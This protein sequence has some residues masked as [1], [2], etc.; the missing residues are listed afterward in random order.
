MLKHVLFILIFIPI[1]LFGQQTKISGVVKDIASG[2][3][4]AF[5][6]IQFVGSKIGVETDSLGQYILETYYATDSVRCFASGYKTMTFPI[7]KDKKQELN[8]NLSI[9]L[10]EIEE[11][12]VLPPDELP[13]VRL[14][15]KI[16]KNKPIND[17]EKL[18]SYEYEVYNK[19]QLD[20]NNLGDKFKNKGL[21]KKMDLILGYIDSIE[22]KKNYL[23]VVFTESLSDYYYVKNPTRKKEVQKASRVVG[24]DN[25]QL[26]QIVGE[27]YLD[28]NIY[29]NNIKVINRTFISPIASF[30]RNHYHFLIVD[31]AYIDK[32][33]C[34]KMTYRPKR[35][36]EMTFE[37]E[38]WVHDTTYAIK[39]IKGTISPNAN[40]NLVQDLVF[41]QNFEMVEHEVWM[42]TEEKIFADFNLL[43]KTS[44]YGV[45]GRKYSSR[46]HFK[47]NQTYPDKFYNS[48]NNVDALDSAK[49]RSQAY[50]ETHRHVPLSF[51]E[52]KITEMADN[53]RKQPFFKNMQSVTQMLV[54]GYFPY[55]YFEFGHIYKLFS[56]NPAEKFRMGFAIR[57]SNKFSKRLELGAKGYYGFGDNKFKY[58]AT[59]R[60]NVTPKKRGM[61]SAYYS[62]DIEQIGTSAKS[63]QVGTTFGTLIRTGPLDKL[64]FVEK[65]GINFEKDIH[66]D[67]IAFTGFEW[68][69]YVPVG[70]ADYVKK[71]L[72][73]G[74]IDSIRSVTATE[75]TLRIRWAKDE[76]FIGGHFD[77][78]SIIKS[79]YPEL[80]FQ[81]ILGIKGAL[82]SDYQYQKY[83]FELN[84]RQTLGPAGYMR[85]GFS[86]GFI[87]GTAA[88]PFLKVHEGSQ[89]YYL[90]KSNFNMMRFYEFVSDKYVDA[91]VENHWGG[92]FLNYIPWVKKLQWRFVTSARTAWGMLDQRHEKA[93]LLPDFIKRFNDTPYL[94]VSLGIENI[95]KFAR[96]DL[97]YR[98]THQ[99]P[100]RSPLGVRAKFEFAL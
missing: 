53:L 28:I 77:R 87:H 79:R 78:V 25:V 35:D 30:A 22:N 89:S 52:V 26:D 12:V 61:L 54:T 81:A 29:D 40:I 88:Y 73:T 24:I 85:Y 18:E 67:F 51:K 76:D 21:V 68:K 11:V 91:Y 45:Y 66:K 82:G 75:V 46:K 32:Y 19:I 34:Y 90:S 43:N 62:Y 2:E 99:V 7:K 17:R 55:G 36:G 57:T 33:W 10:S 48:P 31:S 38:M 39:S 49:L 64:T 47:I 80:S 93:M 4:I 41:E 71:N 94:E 20:L 50:W 23:P 58:G 27:M 74:A 69:N 1:C 65:T 100:G 42:L 63:S 84:H 8:I 59:A 97:F 44:L 37:G 9:Q 13:S 60:F 72:E 16:V 83:E 86:L 3:P 96:V 92:L 95:F 5:A 15:K 56:Y 70:K 6:K 98:V 14:H